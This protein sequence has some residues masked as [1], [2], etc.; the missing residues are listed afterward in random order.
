MKFNHIGLFVTDL[1]IGRSKLCSMLPI[2]DISPIIED[3]GIKVRIQFCTDDSGIRYELVAPWGENNP[4]QGALNSGK[5]ILNHVAYSV[6]N[7][8]QEASRLR[9]EGCIPLGPAQQAVAFN[10]QL[11]IFFMT[12][13]RFIIE[14]IEEKMDD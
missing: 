11:V 14:L 13:L 5:G 12:P 7:L 6:S 2:T 9:E 4:V 1:D 3:P 8:A 10:S